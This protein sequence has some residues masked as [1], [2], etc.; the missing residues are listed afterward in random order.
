MFG[1]A[2]GNRGCM[3]RHRGSHLREQEGSRYAAA[4]RL[5]QRAIIQRHMGSQPAD[6]E[7]YPVNMG[8]NPYAENPM[9]AYRR[10]QAALGRYDGVG[11][12]LGGGLG[13]GLRGGLRGGR[14]RLFGGTGRGQNQFM[15]FDDDDMCRRGRMGLMRRPM[16]SNYVDIDSD[17][18]DDYDY[19]SD[20]DESL[21]FNEYDE[22]FL[23]SRPRGLGR[24]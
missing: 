19:D 21:Y 11:S 6:L 10:M 9:I 23:R 8:R 12:G 24:Y 18:E 16:Y 20:D 22:P 15:G 17:D 7:R 1:N 2:F 5:N 3:P 4:R 14:G 13:G